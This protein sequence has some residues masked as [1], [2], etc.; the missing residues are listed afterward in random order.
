MSIVNSLTRFI[1]L[2]YILP[3]RKIMPLQTFRY[4]VCG[5]ANLVLDWVLYFVLYNF[6][7]REQMLNLGIVVI[8]AHIAAFIIEFPI[9]FFTG[10]WLN[11]NI[12]FPGSQLKQFQQLKRYLLVVC[13]SILLNYICLK[14]FVE[15]ANIHAEIAKIITICITVVYSYI[16]Q[17]HFTFKISK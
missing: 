14:L 13:G 17:K 15:A 10:F 3:F 9:T 1:D 5:G 7:L 6:I 4:G 16:M 12:V 8:S 11:R 2:F